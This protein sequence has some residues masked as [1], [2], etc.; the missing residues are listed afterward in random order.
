MSLIDML[1]AIA[2]GSFGGIL[3]NLGLRAMFP[4]I[5]LHTGIVLL[6]GVPVYLICALPVYRFLDRFQKRNH[7]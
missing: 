5:P 1:I 4:D 7:D 2:L 6:L 3:L